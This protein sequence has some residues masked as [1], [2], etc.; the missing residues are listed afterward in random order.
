MFAFISE[1]IYISALH[2]SSINDEKGKKKGGKQCWGHSKSFCLHV[3]VFASSKREVTRA[4]MLNI[5]RMKGTLVFQNS[6]S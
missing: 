5:I 3:Y 2:Y 6:L 1:T 4:S